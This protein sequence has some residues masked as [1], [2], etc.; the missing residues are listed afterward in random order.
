AEEYPSVLPTVYEISKKIERISDNHIN[1]DGSLCLGSPI[2]LKMV[3]KRSR[4][5]AYFFEK[6]ILPY[7]YAVT[8]KIE[9]GQP[10][11]FG[12]LAHGDVGLIGD[13]Q[14]LFHLSGYNKVHDML[15]ILSTNKK[16]ANRLFCPCGCERRLSSCEYF[17]KVQ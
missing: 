2:R 15:L 1:N 13:F 9:K 6:C 12:G 3:I 10:F 17:K 7:L 14:D 4:R 11:V 8:L 5:L 16:E